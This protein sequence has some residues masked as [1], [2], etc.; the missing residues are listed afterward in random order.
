MSKFFK[1][2]LSDLS[3]YTPGEQP[4]DGE[5][6]KL[7]TNEN[8][9][10]PSKY[11]MDKIGGDE[12]KNLRL[13]SDPDLN[14]LRGAI[15]GY[16]GVNSKNVLATNGSDEALAFCFSAFGEKGAVFPDITYGFYKVFAKLFGVKYREL[17][18][19]SDFTVNLTPYL[20]A[21]ECVFLANPNA[22][23][24]LYKEIDDIEKLVASNIGR[25]VVIDEAYID[26]GGTSAVPLTKKYNNLVVVQTF[27][28]S[29]SL[30]GAR[31][32]FAIADESL[33]EDLNRVKF[34]FNPYN[35]NRLSSLLATEAIKDEDYFN[36]CRRRIMA[37]REKLVGNLSTLGF[38]V[39]PS[40]AN[41]VLAKS[42][43]LGGEEL[44]KK[45]KDK[46][47]LVRHFN[48]ERINDYVRITV[49]SDIQVDFLIK[50]IKEIF[51]E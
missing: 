6:V 42:D 28:K 18:L 11:A 8:P 19:E 10:F 12:L 9:Y 41:F 21:K 49:G 13:Y 3:P 33:I 35:I 5:Y 22:Q 34:S 17:P 36:H 4:R 47:V 37:T 39:L 40:N 51:G 27:S 7:N 23:T 16:Y 44:Y 50:C 26:F 45:L 31:V 24:G 1:S 32:G 20:K 30:A 48:D 29:R 2:S 25:V 46:K 15:A 38:S 43:R 14:D